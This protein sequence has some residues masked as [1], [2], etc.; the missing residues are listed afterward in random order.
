MIAEIVP[1]FAYSAGLA[2]SLPAAGMGLWRRGRKDAAQRLGRPAV[3]DFRN[4]RRVDYGDSQEAAF[5][6]VEATDRW[7]GCLGIECTK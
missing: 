4:I 7:R 6:L 2:F 1:V 3:A 5:A